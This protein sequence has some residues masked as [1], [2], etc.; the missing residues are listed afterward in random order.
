MAEILTSAGA[1]CSYLHY[2]H[3]WSRE[4]FDQWVENVAKLDPFA[5]TAAIAQMDADGCDNFLSNG[6]DP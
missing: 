3:P 4:Q 6:L 5:G 2:D 1:G